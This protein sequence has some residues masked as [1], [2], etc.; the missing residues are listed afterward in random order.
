MEDVCVEKLEDHDSH[1]LIASP[2]D[3]SHGAEPLF[4]FQFLSG[5]SLDHVQELLCDEALELAKGL[6]FKNRSYFLL[7]FPCALAVNQLSNFLE[8]RCRRVLETFL[9]L[10]PALELS[11]LRKLAARQLEKRAHLVV[12]VCSIGCGGQFLPGQQLRDVGLG[13]FGGGR[14][15]L[16]LEP[17]SCQPFP[18]DQADIH[19]NPFEL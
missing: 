11:Q 9:Q 1:L 2:T 8:Q 6:L 7:F 3:S 14:Q 15:I 17:Q 5:D 18:D 12:D 10:C 19:W 16:L 4:V 13:D